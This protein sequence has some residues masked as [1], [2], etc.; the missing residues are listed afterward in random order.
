LQTAVVH[1]QLPT[2]FCPLKQRRLIT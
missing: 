2:P 1:E